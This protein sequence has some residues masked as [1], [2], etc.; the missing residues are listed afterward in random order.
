MKQNTRK[1]KKTKDIFF[2]K[3]VK[4]IYLNSTSSTTTKF[5]TFCIEVSTELRL[6]T[7]SVVNSMMAKTVRPTLEKCWNENVLYIHV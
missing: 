1:I 3:I 2:C 7:S 4:Y 6:N 5:L